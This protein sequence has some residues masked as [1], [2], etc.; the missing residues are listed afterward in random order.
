MG[1]DGRYQYEI[2]RIM[3]QMQ[4]EF[5]SPSKRIDKVLRFCRTCTNSLRRHLG[6]LSLL[7]PQF[8]SRPII[9]ELHNIAGPF[10]I[11]PFPPYMQQ[12]IS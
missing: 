2:L 5:S 7:L 4:E 1:Q 9:S 11:L 8:S 10:F 12:V 3:R 6:K